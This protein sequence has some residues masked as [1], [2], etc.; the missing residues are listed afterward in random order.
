[1][2]LTDEDRKRL[3]KTDQQKILDAT[4]K[5]EDANAKGDE[6]AKQAAAAEAAAIREGNGYYTDSYGRYAGDIA[7]DG[8][9]LPADTGAGI[10]QTSNA[11]E[12]NTGTFPGSGIT[13]TS[14]T[15]NYSLPAPPRSS[16]GTYQV[17]GG[18]GKDFKYDPSD[19]SITVTYT[20]GTEKR[21]T[22]NDSFYEI[23]FKAMEAD[24]GYDFSKAIQDYNK[25][26]YSENQGNASRYNGGFCSLSI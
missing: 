22:E 24:T 5:W 8:S 26:Q 21:L 1:M 14:N 10:I 15:Q 18:S 4:A 7:Q 16:D 17:K 11:A 19:G 23:T 13:T 9:K 20:D 6:A 2:T 12:N 25:M 3:S